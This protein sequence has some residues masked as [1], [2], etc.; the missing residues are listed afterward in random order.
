M[1]ERIKKLAASYR[2]ETVTLRRHFHAHPELSWEETATT[3]KIVETL[4]GLGYHIVK[5]G[6]GGTKSG[7]VAELKGGHG[8][9]CVALRAD[10]DALPLQEENDVPYKSK[11]GGVM[12]ACGHD[13]HAAMLLGAAKILAEIKDELHGTIRLIFQPA[14]ESGLRPGAKIMVE[15]GVLEG[16]DVISGLHIWAP[17]PAGKIVY[18]SG[19]FMAAA[20]GWYLTIQGKGGHGSAP[21][22]S[23]DPT[24]AAANIVLNLQ[25]MM[26]REVS[27]RETAVLSVGVIKAGDTAFNIIPDTVK[28]NGTVRTFRP[29]IQDHVEEAL[30]RT[31]EGA[32]AM[33]RCTFNLEYKRFLPATIND[34]DTTMLLKAPCE[35]LFGAENV[36]ESP[37]IMGSED[38]S[39]FQRE[40][41]GAFFFV[42]G[43]NPE[44]GCN[45][46]HH[47]PKFS[48]DEDAFPVGVAALA[49]FAWTW[50]EKNK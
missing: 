25:E 43:G 22:I 24:I 16:V 37:L 44:K 33:G 5:V 2:E 31:V 19:P 6:F 4:K 29:E 14:E 41:P 12:H 40:I 18:R 15:E 17:E 32:C 47:H 20:D 21:E 35:E 50:L 13:S 39:Y 28:M 9:K 36:E 23:V 1:L 8:G 46:P 49:G 11:A 10:I 48:V 26:A 34:H 38:F 30:R 7:V 42:G 27:A 3:E 45:S